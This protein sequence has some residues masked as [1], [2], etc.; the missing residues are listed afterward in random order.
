[1][2]ETI[3]PLRARRGRRS[4][5]TGRRGALLAA[6]A[7]LVLGCF[8]SQEVAFGQSGKPS[9]PSAAAQVK[10]RVTPPQSGPAAKQPAKLSATTQRSGCGSSKALP[11]PSPTGPHPR[12][13]CENPE[14]TL[15]P[16]WQGEK[17]EVVFKIRN[18]G[19]ADLEIQVK[20]G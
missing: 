19:Q 2:R 7:G 11:Q 10:K 8:A 15:E 9:A 6:C 20:G 18:E 16:V 13:V 14:I 17:A 12:Y 3:Q 5:R 4:V 1:M